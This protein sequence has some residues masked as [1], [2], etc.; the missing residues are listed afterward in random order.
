MASLDAY[1]QRIVDAAPPLIQA[2]KDRLAVLLNADTT[3][4]QC[5]SPND[6]ETVRRARADERRHR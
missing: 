3:P 6:T 5:L 4:A 1:V 2:Q